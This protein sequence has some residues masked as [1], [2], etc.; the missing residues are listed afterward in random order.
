[1]AKDTSVSKV[2]F[3]CVVTVG[4]D[5]GFVGAQKIKQDQMAGPQVDI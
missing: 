4:P 1:M 2:A 3:W 5:S